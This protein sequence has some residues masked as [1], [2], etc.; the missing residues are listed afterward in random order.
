[1]REMVREVFAGGYQEGMDN[2]GYEEDKEDE[3]DF[4]EVSTGRGGEM[5]A[6]QYEVPIDVIKHFSN[7]TMDTFQPLSKKWQT[8]LG[9]QRSG[10]PCI[11]S[12]TSTRIEYRAG[13]WA[14]GLSNRRK[15]RSDLTDKKGKGQ[16]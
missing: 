12:S 1:M 16:L 6:K 9:R 15:I 10:S 8:F 3:G 7:K 4:L 11:E 2:G 13:E 14:S 5:G